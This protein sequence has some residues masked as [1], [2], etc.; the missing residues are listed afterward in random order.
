MV[1]ADS[2]FSTSS[3]TYNK[4]APA[5]HYMVYDSIIRHSEVN[6]A[7]ACRLRVEL[8]TTTLTLALNNLSSA[9]LP[10]D[11]AI[12]LK[13]RHA[14]LEQLPHH[15]TTARPLQRDTFEFMISERGMS[16]QP[17]RRYAEE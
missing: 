14:D 2:K 12:C 7:F 8:L 9:D 11:P 15:H 16:T 17:C 4:I 5:S 6:S 13:V 1:E 10:V 3:T